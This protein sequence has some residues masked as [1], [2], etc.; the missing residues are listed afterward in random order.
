MFILKAAG[1]ALWSFVVLLSCYFAYDI[2]MYAIRTYGTVIHEFGALL[3][4]D[5]VV[6][7]AH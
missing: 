6:V 4:D 3:F 2:R 1:W 5:V 7:P